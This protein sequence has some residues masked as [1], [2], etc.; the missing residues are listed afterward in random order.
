MRMYD[1]IRK[2]RDGGKLDREE[3]AFFVRGVTAGQYHS[4]VYATFEIQA[5]DASDTLSGGS[6]DQV[7]IHRSG[8]R[9]A[10]ADG[11]RIWMVDLE[12][13]KTLRMFEGSLF[14]L[15][16]DVTD[17]GLYFRYLSGNAY[18]YLRWETAEEVLRSE[19][20]GVLSPDGKLLAAARV[21]DGFTVYDTATGE[22]VWEDGF[23]SSNTIYG[24][25]FADN[26]TLIASHG[27]VQIYRISGRE[28]VYDSGTD[29]ASYGYDIAAGRLVMPLR[30]GGCLINLMPAEEDVL[31]HK[32]VESR[33]AYNPDDI[34]TTTLYYPLMGSW[35]GSNFGYFDE[36]GKM[37]SLELDE[38]GLAYVFEGETY[39]IHPVN[40]VM[41]NF[42][43]ISP[44]GEWQALIRGQDVD[45]FR[46]KEGP[47]PVMTI[48][49][50]FYDRLCAAIYGD[51]LVLGTYVENLS[52]YDLKTGECIGTLD[53]GA[54]CQL[55]QF[56]RDGRQ[57]ITLSGL[58]KQATVI[59]MEN[60]A[61]IMKIPV[62]DSLYGVNGLTVGFNEEGTEAVV[63]HPDGRADVGMLVTDLDKLV[64]KARKYTTAD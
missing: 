33:E 16:I 49:G 3:I 34:Y 51:V 22:A 36:N 45:I 27:Q 25:A 48:P 31:P 39:V 11:E 62:P 58:A 30:S 1:I 61:V 9:G 42:I 47:E 40:S 13:G 8:R 21:I 5:R 32:V 57:I 44:D 43:Y 19:H 20:G 37:V 18:V 12:T 17:D 15:F 4:S 26:D 10:W 53:T 6:S 46:A 55:I 35:N 50:T 63:L 7:V 56:S 28:L 60:F 54:M 24:L 41:G 23:N 14:D 2:K 52:L 29:R 59:S 38:P 64:E